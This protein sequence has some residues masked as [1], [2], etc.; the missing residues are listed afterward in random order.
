MAAALA[1]A[2]ACQHVPA[3]DLPRAAASASLDSAFRVYKDSVIRS[4]SQP[5]P[6]RQVILHNLMI[7][8]DGKVVIEENFDPAWPATRPQH[9]F[10]ASKTFTALAVGLA[11][12]DGLL[13][14]DDSVARFFPD[15][16]KADNPCRATLRDLLTMQGGHDTD[17]TWDTMAA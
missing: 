11:V 15:K 5:D 8:K 17:P 6:N 3:G 10:S 14:V 2:A 4:E 12:D 16:V 1:A 9:V 13:S 7:L